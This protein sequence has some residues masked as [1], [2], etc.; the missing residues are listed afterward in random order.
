[1]AETFV[2]EM[3]TADRDRGCTPR[4]RREFVLDEGHGEVVRAELFVTALGVVEAVVNGM[5]ASADLLTPGW[6]S[7]EWRVRYARWDVTALIEQRNAIGLIIGNGWHTGYL[8]FLGSRGLYGSERAAFAELRITFA[9]W[10][11]QTIATDSSWRSGP[12]EVLAD[13]LY[14]GQT[15]DARL[16]DSHWTKYGASLDDWSGVRAVDFDHQRLTPY[17]GPPVRR[18]ETLAP[19]QVRTSPAGATLVDF[20]QNLVGWVRL[21]V[22]GEAGRKIVVRHAE[23]LE[24][25][26][27]GTRPLRTAKATDTFVLSGGEDV[28]EPTLT[29]HGFRYV[30]VDG[31]TGS[32][33]ELRASLVAQVIGSDLKRIGTFECSNPLLNQLHSNI[34][35]S[36]RGNFVDVPTDCPQRDERLGWTGDL[37]AFADT[38]AYLY[39]VEAFLRDWLLDLAAEQRAADGQ[40]GVVVPDCLKLENRTAFTPP[41]G[42]NSG[43]PLIALWNDAAAWVPW[44]LYQAYGDIDVLATQYES[45]AMYARRIDQALSDRDLLEDG[46]QLGD[47][48]DPTAPPDR[49]FEAKADKYVIATACVH[50]S[51]LIAADTARLLGHDADAADLTDLATRIRTAFNTHWVENGR[52]RSDAPAVYALAICFGLLDGPATAAAGTRL[53][54]LVAASD[55]H[56]T[57]GFA[58]TP[59]I[60]RAL[61]DTGHTDTAYRLPPANPN[62]LPLM[63]LPGNHG[64]HHHLGTLG[65]HAPRRHHQ[66]RRDDQLQPLRLRRHRHLDAPHHRR[67]VPPHPRLPKHP[68]RPDPRRRPH[69]GPHLTTHPTRPRRIHLDPHRQ[70]IDRHRNNSHRSHRRHPPPRTPRNNGRQRN[71]HLHHRTLIRIRSPHIAFRSTRHPPDPTA[72]PSRIIA[73]RPRQSCPPPGPDQS[74]TIRTQFSTTGLTQASTS[75]I[76]DRPLIETPT[77][78][79][80]LP[81]QRSAQTDGVRNRHRPRA[82]PAPPRSRITLATPSSETPTARTISLAH[83]RHPRLH[84]GRHPDA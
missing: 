37:A 67:P 21:T 69:L 20:G 46:I 76:P 72:P 59:F 14:Q 55:H 77:A 83:S 27:L 47:W 52:I 79:R 56:I 61:T 71:P 39:D 41:P 64:R 57:T 9:D 43:T 78:R 4:L 54:E 18:Q 10:H 42:K 33:D 3:I 29:F 12:S 80:S 65:L 16:R 2:A 24:H 13:D 31:W 51:A 68:H 40:L 25:D 8:G 75:A 5:V 74:R 11:R 58:G 34:V 81:T 66:P 82:A 17:V 73:S 45:I 6:S 44:A 15:I 63:A 22:T 32:H 38:A 36:M 70:P 7:Y 48:L 26:E 28:F 84:S 19:Q 35:W 60:A 62:R 1:M 30:Q 53:A 50:R 49:P 23:V